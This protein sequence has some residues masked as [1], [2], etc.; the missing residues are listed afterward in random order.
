M[1]KGFVRIPRRIYEEKQWNNKR[2]YSELD[3][4]HDLYASASTREHTEPDGTK[5]KRDQLSVSYR[6]LADRWIWDKM[7]VKRFILSL[8][9]K[10]YITVS[11]NKFK[12]ILTIVDFGQKEGVS[13]ETPTDTPFDTPSD[14]PCDTPKAPKTKVFYDVSDTPDDTPCDTPCDTQPDT[15]NKEYKNNN[16]KEINKESDEYSFEKFW[17]LYDKKTGKGMCVKAYT[18]LS[19]TDKKEIFEYLPKYKQTTP[20]KKYRKNPLTF[21]HERAWEDEL[22]FEE[23]KD[24][25]IWKLTNNDPDKFKDGFSW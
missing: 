8:E 22:I 19:L 1:C 14:T 25:P 15:L 2:M 4:F 7:R 13:S 5:I 6:I 23:P 10:G 16:K 21:I 17:D 24:N 11:S 12:T 18:R 3:A 20:N 9:K